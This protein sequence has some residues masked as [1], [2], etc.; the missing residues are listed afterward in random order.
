MRNTFLI[1]HSLLQTSD[2]TRGGELLLNSALNTN[3]F[4]PTRPQSVRCQCK[5]FA[6]KLIWNS[7]CSLP[8]PPRHDSSPLLLCSRC[9]SWWLTFL[10]DNG[11]EWTAYRF[12]CLDTSLRSGAVAFLCTARWW[13]RWQRPPRRRCF[14]LESDKRGGKIGHMSTND[15]H[16]TFSTNLFS[17]CA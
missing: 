12:V 17:L 6:L 14:K 9:Q 4:H 2:G 1:I 8:P 5:A 11:T 15:K 13:R 7:Y 16:G 10:P 3:S